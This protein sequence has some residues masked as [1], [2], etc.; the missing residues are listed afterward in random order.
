MERFCLGVLAAALM[1]LW[2]PALPHLIWPLLMLG[3]ALLWRSYTLAGCCA[4]LLSLAIHQ[5]NDEKARQQLL[6]QPLRTV[7]GTIVSIPQTYDLG[8]R[9]ILQL[10][11]RIEGQPQDA[12]GQLLQVRWPQTDIQLKQ[13]QQWQFR[14]KMRA[15]RGLAN[16]GRGIAEATAIA[17]GELLQGTVLGDARYLGG[18][19]IWRQ[20]VY[21]RLHHQLAQYSTAPLLIALTV[22][23][24]PFS[25]ITWDGLQATGLSHLISI[26]GMHIALVFGWFMLLQPLWRQLPIAAKPRQ[27]LGWLLALLAA[28]LYCLLA[29]WAIPTLRAMLA[30]ILLVLLRVLYRRVSGWRF[31]L[32]L[33][34]ALLLW[35]PFWLLSLS[36]WLSVSAVALVFLLAW[37]YPVV[38]T[39]QRS[40]SVWPRWRDILWHFLRYQ[41]IFSMLMLPLGLLIFA[42]IAPLALISNL[43]FVPWC[44]LVA[45]PILLATFLLQQLSAVP[46]DLLWQGIDW[47]FQPL[48]WWIQ[49]AAASDSW[50]SLPQ[51]Q[52]FVAMLLVAAGCCWLVPQRRIRWLIA[53]VSIWPLWWVVA[54]PTEPKLHLVDVG[55]GTSVVLQRGRHALVYDLGPRYG[56]YSATKQQLLP[57]LRYQGIRELDYVVISHDDSDHTG[58]P[59]VL[60][61]AYPQAQWVSDVQRLQPDLTCRQLPGAWQGFKLQVLWPARQSGVLA[62]NDNSCILLLSFGQQTILVTG[63][64]SKEV[65]QQLMVAHPRLQADVLILGHHGSQTS[66]SLKFLQQLKPALALNSA[67]WQNHY[68]HPARSVVASLNLLQIPLWNTAEYGALTLTLGQPELKLQSVRH[69]RLVKWLENLPEHAE[70]LSATR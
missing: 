3:V 43:V 65:E 42:G 44:S 30:L 62:K 18:F 13:G 59:T 27:L 55:Q 34:A 19:A 69:S 1:A 67:G 17:Q 14:L 49:Y 24:R 47:I 25:D 58:D 16:P 21:D 23:E 9:F 46:L 31:S 37:R 45:I 7:A 8:R 64:A 6:L 2:L 66:S 53:L 10:H 39:E 50:W 12:A 60:K 52:P 29:G 63:D 33:T 57:F 26:S 54:S 48:W 15:V 41:L 22:G 4:F 32:V 40:F 70:T 28:C 51:Q 5:H 20:Q 35:Q 61:Q 68:Q 56:S 36:F 11:P 38:V